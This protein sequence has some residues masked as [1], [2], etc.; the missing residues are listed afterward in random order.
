MSSAF[1]SASSNISGYP[2]VV[3]QNESKAV[4]N[5][6]TSFS[7]TTPT[8]LGMTQSVAGMYLVAGYLNITTATSVSA[9]VEITW[10]DENSGAHTT[11]IVATASDGA[12]PVVTALTTAGYRDFYKVCRAK[13]ATTMTILTAGTFTTSVTDFGVMVVLLGA[14]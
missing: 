7:L 9:N 14:L 3:Y 12:V 6:A 13:N 11:Q 4:S 1:A 8:P 5:A 2:T 10:T